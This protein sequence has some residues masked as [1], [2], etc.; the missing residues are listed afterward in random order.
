MKLGLTDFSI[1]YSSIHHPP[2]HPLHRYEKDLTDKIWL[3]QEAMR[4]L[5]LQAPAMY[6]EAL[7][8]D[9][10]PPPPNRPFPLWDTPPI[11]DFDWKAYTRQKAEDEDGDEEE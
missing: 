5:A 11:E 7:I 3:Q 6:H 9:E 2:I 10:T 4:S 1:I 8:V